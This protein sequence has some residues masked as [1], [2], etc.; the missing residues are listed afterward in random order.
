LWLNRLRSKKLLASV[1]RFE[2]FPIVLE[3]WRDLLEDEFDLPTLR[4]VLDDIA[5]QRTTLHVT[6]PAHPTPFSD[7][8]TFR[9]TNYHMYLDDTP[10]GAAR[11][12]LSEDLFRDLLRG[13]ADQPRVP[14]ALVAAFSAKLLRTHPD[15]RPST[16]TEILLAVRELLLVPKSVVDDW[17]AHGLAEETDDNPLDALAT[18]LL[19]GASQ[20]LVSDLADL[21]RIVTLRGSGADEPELVDERPGQRSYLQ[22][23]VHR[24]E[25]ESAADLVAEMLRGRALASCTEITAELGFSPTELSPLFEELLESERMVAGPLVQGR[26]EPLFCDAENAERLLRLLRAA[27][28]AQAEANLAARP[29]DDLQPFLAEWQGLGPTVGGLEALQQTL[30]RLFGFPA[31][32]GLWEEAILPSR[33][34]PYY[35]SWLDIL[36]ASYGLGWLGIGKERVT[37]A[38]PADNLLFSDS[39]HH[40]EDAPATAV[41]SKLSGAER[42]LG[43]FDLANALGLDTGSLAEALWLLAWQGQVTSDSFEPV[44]RGILND[45]SAEKVASMSGREAFRRWE[46]SRPGVGAWQVVSRNKSEGAMASAELDK[47]RARMVLARHG[48]IFRELLEHELP[49]L[50]WSRLFRALRL[51]ELSG[52][53]VAGHFFDGIPGLQFATHEAIRKLAAPLPSDRLYFINA[54]DPA[55]LCGLGLPGLPDLPRRI[56][57]HWTVFRGRDLV[58]T[59]EKS[60]RDLTVVPP[61]GDPV[62]EPALGIYAF[63]LGRQFNP[64]SSLTVETING[65]AAQISPYVEHLR[66]IGF[67]NDYRGLSLW[68]R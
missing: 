43:F 65:Q 33:L 50:R 67:A 13:A 46:R 60:G 26:D 6:R 35:P 5:A 57:S 16:R 19:P 58:L 25:D 39:V 12:N 23:H 45:F 14:P 59:L 24:L 29:L 21:P 38:F 27:R 55:S 3:T 18:Y 8:I 11:S 2:D 61:P 32:A 28:R 51:L 48:V 47:E 22:K 9:Q 53:I 4:A 63:L 31:P 44:R 41:L 68:R 62:V 36:F 66:K 52:E 20:P 7:G 17:V 10:G 34:A 42:G 56:A 49:F 64:A 37:L 54:C 30:D 1:L 40:Q 15:Y